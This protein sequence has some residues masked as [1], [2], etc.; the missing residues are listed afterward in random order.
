MEALL[1]AFLFVKVGLY[2]LFYA[3]GHL[4]NAEKVAQYIGWKSNFFQKEVGYA[5]LAFGVLGVLS[6]WMQDS[7]WTATIIGYAVFYIGCGIIHIEDMKS[8]G[9]HS[10]GNNWTHVLLICFLQPVIGIVLL[11]AKSLS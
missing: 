3:S 1:L 11:L 4:F 6:F 10:G 9:N 8:N 2:G 5:N 7:F